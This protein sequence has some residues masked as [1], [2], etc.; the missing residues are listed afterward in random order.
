MKILISAYSC[1]TGR[2]SEGEIGWRMV[3]ALAKRHEVRVITRANLRPVHEATFAEVPRPAGLTFEYFDLPW[4]FR[5]YKK[6]K[7]FFLVYYYLWQIGV[8]LRA[9]RLLRREPADVLHHLIGGMDWMPAGLALCPGPFVWGPVGSEDTHPVILRHL[10]L[11]S[12]LKDGLRVAMRGLLR[13]VEPFTRLTAARADII[14]SHTPETMP[15]RLAARLRPFT[16]TGIADLPGLARPKTDLARGPRLRLVYAGELKDWKGARMALDASLAFLETGAD[17]DL[18][19]IGD[20]PLRADMEAVA[21]AHPQGARVTFL[22]K[23]PMERLIDELHAGD[24]FLY[25]SFHHGLATIVL[26]A[27]LTG[28]PVVC[29]A[30]DATGRAVGQEA[31]VTVPLSE[32]EAPAEGLARAIGELA[33]DEDRRQALAAS[34]RRIAL[35]RH[36]YDALSRQVEQVY[37]DALSGTSAAG[38]PREV[39]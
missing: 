15:R 12:R 30:G 22:G 3:N 1:E 19:V 28:L 6:G 18:V 25:P 17:A 8:G 24:L 35:E 31:G 34:A 38:K 2:G 10:S 13:T 32:D 23:V 27:M 21:R 7:R 16:Q 39:P 36:S 29:I 33:A 4:I 5:F 14:L 26:Q 9:R 11:K 20:G 37:R